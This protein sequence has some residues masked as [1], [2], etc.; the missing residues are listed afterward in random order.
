M[1]L[2]F[3]PICFLQLLVMVVEMQVDLEMVVGVGRVVVMGRRKLWCCQH[4]G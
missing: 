3:G 2:S 4:S 1:Q